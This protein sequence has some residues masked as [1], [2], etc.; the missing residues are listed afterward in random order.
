MLSYDRLGDGSRVASLQQL[1]RELTH[2]VRALHTVCVVPFCSDPGGQIIKLCFGQ[3]GSIPTEKSRGKQ[4][5][6]LLMLPLLLLFPP[7]LLLLLLLLRLG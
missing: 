1:L 2:H 5:R 6:G 4:E 3:W 7:L